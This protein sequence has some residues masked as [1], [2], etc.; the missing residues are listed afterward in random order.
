MAAT[1]KIFAFNPFVENT[2]VLSDE[3]KEAV[4]IDPG[5]S[6][7]AEEKELYTYIETNGLKP[8]AL[9]NTHCHIDHVLGNRFVQNRYKLPLQAH[10]LETS[11]IDRSEQMASMFG[12]PA[13]D[14]PA[15]EKFLDQGDVVTFGNTKLEVLFTPG[16]ASGHIAFYDRAG[17]Y[18]IAGDV[19]FRQ[20]VGRTDLPG[21][22][23]DVLYKSIMEV[24]MPLG[25]AIKIYPGHGPE[26]TLGYEKVNNPFLQA[27]AWG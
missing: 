23:F 16:H 14:S 25:D 8:V 6:H 21:G 26:T 1:L 3:T 9:L 24:L 17:G 22:S 18:V 20:S 19:L 4:I 15:I 5:C 7:A 11:N 12:M 2:Y 27:E 10:K 13:P